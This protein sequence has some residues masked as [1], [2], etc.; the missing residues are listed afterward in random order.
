MKVLLS[1]EVFI[2]LL[3]VLGGENKGVDFLYFLMFDME[4][5]IIVFGEIFRIFNDFYKVYILD[6]EEFV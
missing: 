6:N 4:N 1:R 2:F 5:Y 3:A